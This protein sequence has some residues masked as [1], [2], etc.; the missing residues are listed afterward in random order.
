[1]GLEAQIER[2]RVNVNYIFLAL[3]RTFAKIGKIFEP[4]GLWR[5]GLDPLMGDYGGN[6]RYNAATD[7]RRAGS[8]PT[9]RSRRDYGVW[10]FSPMLENLSLIFR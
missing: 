4:E 5:E 9:K 10:S 6:W 3:R 7:G 2:G 8:T 1:M